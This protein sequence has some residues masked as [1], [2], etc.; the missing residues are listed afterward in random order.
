ME[1]FVLQMPQLCIACEKKMRERCDECGRVFWIKN[2]RR[3]I[4]AF[5]K[6]KYYFYVDPIDRFVLAQRIIDSWA[7]C[8]DVL[9]IRDFGEALK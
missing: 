6:P 9:A 5:F 2:I 1:R 3:A 7:N 8:E 4:W